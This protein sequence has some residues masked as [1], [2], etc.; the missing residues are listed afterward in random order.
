MALNTEKVD[1]IVKNNN[2][3]I[4]ILKK[5]NITLKSNNNETKEIIEEYKEKIFEDIDSITTKKKAD[6]LIKKI[7]NNLNNLLY[8]LGI[9]YY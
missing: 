8:E 6:I 5:Q 9:E 3:I 4:E 1:N 2:I 7:E